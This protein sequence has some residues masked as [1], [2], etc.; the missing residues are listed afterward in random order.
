MKQYSEK[1]LRT[2]ERILDAASRL[3]YLNGYN[4]TGLDRII[5]EAGVTKGNFYYHFK[6]KEA[7]AAAT[8]EW[9]KQ[10]AY[11]E[12]KLAPTF[13]GERPLAILFRVLETMIE[14]TLCSEDGC[15][16]RGC[17]FGNLALELSIN[18]EP[19]RRAVSDVF[20]GV[21]GSF[22]GLLQQAREAGELNTAI[23]PQQAASLILSLM[24]GAVMMAKTAQN[25][26]EARRALAFIKGWLAPAR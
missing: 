23:D 25:D 17:Y 5:A 12:L 9:H 1:A 16:I 14:R 3:F 21:R 24:E 20:E 13:P 7:L 22:A 10:E 4:A 26:R 11:R 18:S 19:V 2:R 6:T 15:E 8:V